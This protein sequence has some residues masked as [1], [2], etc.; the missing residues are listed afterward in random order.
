M[1]VNEAKPCPTPGALCRQSWP[2]CDESCWSRAQERQGEVA[3]EKVCLLPCITGVLPTHA[4]F[5]W[6]WLEYLEGDPRCIAAW[7]LSSLNEMGVVMAMEMGMGLVRDFNVQSLSFSLT[8]TRTFRPPPVNLY[9]PTPPFS[10]PPP[11]LVSP[12][13]SLCEYL[14]SIYLPVCLPMG[15]LCTGVERPWHVA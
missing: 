12:C 2:S 1:E 10:S 6:L 7:N 4:H 15:N 5:I 3:K 13:I 9:L 8:H 11:P 14:C